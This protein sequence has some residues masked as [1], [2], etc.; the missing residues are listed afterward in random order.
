MRIIEWPQF[1][2]SGLPTGDK[3]SS[4]TIGIFDGV[5]L[6]H[7]AL[8]KRVDSYSADYVPVVITFRE[9][10]KDDSGNIQ[11]FEQRTAMFETLGVQITL[12]IDFTDAFMRMSG[13]EFLRLLH[14][15]ANP[16]F[17]AIGGNF[18]CGYQGDTNAEAIRD[19]FTAANIPVEIVPDVLHDS[20]PVSSSRIRAAIA[21][22]D[23]AQAQAMLGHPC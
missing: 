8:I 21:S 12:V 17:L 5:H 18:C 4:I 10:L 13:N 16:G 20:L 9:S 3:R 2:Q 14:A 7:R 15:H 11:S 19:F 22:G 23:L 1:L 6:G